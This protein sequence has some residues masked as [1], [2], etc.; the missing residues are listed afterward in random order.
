MIKF[1]PQNVFK[2]TTKLSRKYGEYR[3]T[4]VTTHATINTP[5]HC[6]TFVKITKPPS[7]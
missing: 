7:T 3:K 6:G 4:P 1:I 5:Y 2:S